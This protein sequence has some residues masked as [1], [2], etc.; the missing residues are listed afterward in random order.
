MG[1]LE[2]AAGTLHGGPAQSWIRAQ[3]RQCIPQKLGWASPQPVGKTARFARVLFAQ[4][5]PSPPGGGGGG[6]GGGGEEPSVPRRAL[7]QKSDPLS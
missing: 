1:R 2:V 5:S 3:A 6:D 7:H 4:P